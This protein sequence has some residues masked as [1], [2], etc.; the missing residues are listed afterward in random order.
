M[1]VVSGRIV[2]TPDIAAKVGILAKGAAMRNVQLASD[3]PTMRKNTMIKPA[4]VFEKMK[5]FQRIAV[6]IHAVR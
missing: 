2:N 3:Q 5:V 4:L 1:T 6:M